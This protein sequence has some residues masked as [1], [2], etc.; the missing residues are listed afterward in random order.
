MKFEYLV[1]T[2]IA[3]IAG[4]FVLNLLGG[5]LREFVEKSAQLIAG[6]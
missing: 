4:A 1:A 3:V 6:N 2:L 5:D